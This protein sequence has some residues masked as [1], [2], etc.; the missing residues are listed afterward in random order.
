MSRLPTKQTIKN[1]TIKDMKSLGVHK[2]EYNRIVDIYADLVFQYNEAM[3]AFEMSGRQYETETAAGG[4]K[5]SA[6]AAS[7]EILRKDIITY[8][9]RLGLT[10]KAFETLTAEYKKVSALALALDRL[11][12]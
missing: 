1:A 10:P 8:S 7:L 9:D 6:T 12:V 11:E 2:P 5:K 3:Q 4:T